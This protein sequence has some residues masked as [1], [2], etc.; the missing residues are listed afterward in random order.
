M[1]FFLPVVG[2][3]PSP[4]VVVSSCLEPVKM[5]RH[6][7]WGWHGIRVANQ[8]TLRGEILPDSPDP[9]NV[10]TRVLMRGGR[11]IIDGKR[12]DDG[13]RGWSNVL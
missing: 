5:L 11:R 6:V 8:V 10:I 9:S 4:K 7:A 1:S 12:C 3:I 13:S 2:R